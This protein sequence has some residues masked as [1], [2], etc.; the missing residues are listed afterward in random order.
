M[1]LAPGTYRL[2]VVAR[3]TGGVYSAVV[4]ETLVVPAVLPPQVGLEAPA[5]AGSTSVSLGYL[6]PNEEPVEVSYAVFNTATD[7]FLSLT[8]PDFFFAWVT[9]PPLSRA[10]LLSN[11]GDDGLYEAVEASFVR[12]DYFAA[13]IDGGDRGVRALS[14]V[15]G[16]TYRVYAHARAQQGAAASEISQFEFTVPT[17]SASGSVA[18]PLVE[19]A[20]SDDDDAYSLRVVNVHDEP[21]SCS[22]PCL[23]GGLWLVSAPPPALRRCLISPFHTFR[24]RLCPTTPTVANLLM[25]RMAMWGLWA[26]IFRMA[27]EPLPLLCLLLPTRSRA[28]PT[29]AL[30]TI[31]AAYRGVM[32][33][34]WWPSQAR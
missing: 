23:R 16:L 1:D 24:L 11:V 5:V 20:P 22:G 3:D 30:C 27:P 13:P 21:V 32:L 19:M 25:L 31:L 18:A 9:L 28:P 29:T 33:S 12:G 2:Y 26:Y 10:L 7:D 17:P 8:G 6:N 4:A 14:V 34:T 15:P